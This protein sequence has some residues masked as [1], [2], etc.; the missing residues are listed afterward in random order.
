MS[1]TSPTTAQPA[2]V[3]T[4]QSLADRAEAAGVQ[5]SYI[6]VDGNRVQTTDAALEG[7]LSALNASAYQPLP[8]TP[9]VVAWEGKLRSVERHSV[10]RSAAPFRIVTE[11]G[12]LVEGEAIGSGDVWTMRVD[13]PLGYHQL[14]LGNDS[15]L[16]IAAPQRAHP[17]AKPLW[18]AFA[19]VYALRRDDDRGIGDLSH[20]RE[21]IEWTSGHGGGLIAT[22][23][24]LPMFLEADR[25]PDEAPS[26]YSPA[27]VLFWNELFLDPSAFPFDGSLTFHGG[28]SRTIDYDTAALQTRTLV[29]RL[30]GDVRIDAWAAAHPRVTEYA[31]FR[32]YGEQHGQAWRSWPARLRDGNITDADVD[33]GRMRWHLAAQ[34]A[35]DLQLRAT[36]KASRDQNVLLGLDYPVGVH[37]DGYDIWANQ[38]V[39][40]DGVT[41]GAP[42]DTFFA[43]GQDWQLVPLHP[44]AS[45]RSGH[46]YLREALR[47]QIALGGLLR[48]DHIMGL[49]RR[50]WI[51][52]GGGA[53]EGAYVAY[54]ADELL[55][56]ICLESARAGSVI[57]GENL[58]TV[59]P[60]VNEALESH[61]ILGM[62]IGQDH[63]DDK[64]NLTT[65]PPTQ[66]MSMVNTH[67]MAPFVE[68]W[69]D[70]ASTLE[71]HAAFDQ[72]T[73][74][75]LDG[76]SQIVVVSLEDLWLE[77]ERQNVPGSTTGNWR[78]RIAP[79]ISDID[80]ASVSTDFPPP[81]N[82]RKY[83]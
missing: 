62:F 29:D 27:S 46:E 80:V 82:A 64:A 16:I 51:P 26:P 11:G 8:L 49:F 3:A 60:G 20:L 10:A 56:I 78:Q 81:P 15:C 57:V 23:P 76:P 50:W 32:A 69:G 13:L 52:A 77:R 19:P 38:D 4:T 70:R 17:V 39:F 43:G 44:E 83:T 66:V 7:V 41:V 61:G 47:H 63:V 34:W 5:T 68:A 37:L 40:V 1:S 24:L 14:H 18:G 6:D 12:D 74:E 33:P 35:I 42:P 45:R 53:T 73:S 2:A 30:I 9:V 54:P 55:A 71:P 79:T 67:D 22:L 59:P 36:A 21:L 25:E 48:I 65:Q 75:L 72:V 28:P 31:R 58:G